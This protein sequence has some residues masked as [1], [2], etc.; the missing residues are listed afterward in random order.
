MPEGVVQEP[1]IHSPHKTVETDGVVFT[2]GAEVA[3][4]IA[5]D[6]QFKN[7][8]VDVVTDVISCLAYLSDD[9]AGDTFSATAPSSVPTGDDL[10]ILALNRVFLL[11]TTGT[12]GKLTVNITEAGADTW[13]LVVVLPSGKIAVSD[14]ITFV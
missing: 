2:V 3:N 9:A 13:F 4:V 7:G 12:D 6:V 1:A 14:A 8:E 10:V 5:V 11:V